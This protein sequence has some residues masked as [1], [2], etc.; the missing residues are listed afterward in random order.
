MIKSF[1]DFRYGKYSICLRSCEGYD[2]PTQFE[3]VQSSIV[4]HVHKVF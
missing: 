3:G 4:T 1:F 2:P